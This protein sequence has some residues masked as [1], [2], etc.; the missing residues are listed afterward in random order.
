MTLSLPKGNVVKAPGLNN[1]FR[2]RGAPLARDLRSGATLLNANVYGLG[3]FDRSRFELLA[4]GGMD[5]GV[6]VGV[7]VG[8]GVALNGVH[9]L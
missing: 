4:S 2:L 6:K 5:I 1:A 9:P 3:V 7:M 8:A